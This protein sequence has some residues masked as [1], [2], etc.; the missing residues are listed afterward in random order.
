VEFTSPSGEKG[1]SMSTTNRG[2][3]KVATNSPDYEANG[4]WAA[5]NTSIDAIDAALGVEVKSSD[6]GG[7]AAIASKE[8]T[9][10]LTKSSAGAFTLAA[11]TAGLPSAGG[12]DGKVLR[13]IAGSAQA[14]TVTQT[15]PGFNNGGSAKDVATFGGA[16]GDSMEV[17]AY[18]G[19]WLTTILRNVTLG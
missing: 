12:D 3:G 2:F 15:T 9:V 8:G 14:H 10:L 7:L 1:K 17:V 19:E 11:P 13:I 6:T 4:P 5:L 18:N 16:I